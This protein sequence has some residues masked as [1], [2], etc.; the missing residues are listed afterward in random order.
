[1]K[2]PTCKTCVYASIQ[3]T[4][5]GGTCHFNPPSIDN[6]GT[7][8]WPGVRGDDWCGKHQDASG[9]SV[10][11]A[12]AD[13]YARHARKHGV[14]AEAEL[15]TYQEFTSA[16]WAKVRPHLPARY[17]RWSWGDI[18]VDLLKKNP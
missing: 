8:G 3:G 9:G 1:M 4:D 17:E 10:A 14:E 2:H 18:I 15:K 5:S 12:V 6:N 7:S 11:K 13:M 16:E